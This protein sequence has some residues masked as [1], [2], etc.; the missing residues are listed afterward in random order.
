MSN[1][2]GAQY[3]KK[4]IFKYYTPAKT[5][6]SRLIRNRYLHL[7]YIFHFRGIARLGIGLLARIADGKDVVQLVI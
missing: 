4:R 3:L 6:K 2:E 5:C 1:K 7:L